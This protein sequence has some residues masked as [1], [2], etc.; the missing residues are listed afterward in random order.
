MEPEKNPSCIMVIF[1]AA[2]DL[3]KRKLIPALYNLK[4]ANLLS[5]SF[6]VVGVARAVMSDEEFRQRLRDELREFAT[7]A[8]EAET[9]DWLAARLHYLSGDFADEQ[10]FARLKARLAE[11]DRER[12]APGNYVF[13]LATAPQYFAPVVERL[14]GAGIAGEGSGQWR[15]VIIEKPFGSDVESARQLNRDLSRVLGEDQI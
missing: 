7:E 3:T 5:D 13:Y 4:Q 2:G 10:T 14:G 15:R 1:G 11:V 6:A 12:N 8:I 9:W